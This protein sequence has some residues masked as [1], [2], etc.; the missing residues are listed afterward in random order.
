MHRR[1]IG[2]DIG[3]APAGDQTSFS[4]TRDAADIQRMIRVLYVDEAEAFGGSLVVAGMLVK[5]LDKRTFS[6]SVATAFRDEFTERLF[7]DASATYRRKNLLAYTDMERLRERV[8]RV[9]WGWARGLLNVSLSVLDLLTSTKYCVELALLILAK[10]ITVVHTNNSIEAAI[11]ALL[12]RTPVL[13]HLHGTFGGPL[14]GRRRYIF[15]KCSA[16]V[17]I[18][19]YVLGSAEQAGLDPKRIEIVPNGTNLPQLNTTDVAAI[20]QRWNI[21]LDA[22]LIVLVGR[23]VAWKGHREFVQAAIEVRRRHP[24]AHF[25]FV[26]GVSDGSPEFL[27][28][29]LESGRRH[30]LEGHLHCTGYTSDV[31]AFIEASTVVVHASIEPEPF[32]LVII[33]GMAMGRPVVASTLGAGPEIIQEGIDGLLA[34]PRDRAQLAGAICSLLEDPE[35]AASIGAQARRTVERK[36]DARIMAHSFERIYRRIAQRPE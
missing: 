21:P 12:T 10:R 32:G 35:R 3:G 15:H 24:G 8:A 13:F 29:L 27:Q 5:G 14:H 34:D 7:V 11:A 30:G 36:Y 9:R 4:D 19:R 23:V 1:P 16:I 25:M 17:S 28:E 22:P 18:S 33:E 20:R 6:T 2:R 26:G 31:P